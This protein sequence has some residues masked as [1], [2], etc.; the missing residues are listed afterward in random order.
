MT[1][2]LLR[3][4]AVMARAAVCAGLMAL[5]PA[6]QAQD[7][8]VD[9]KAAD[10]AA[11]ARSSGKALKPALTVT[12]IAPQR[13]DIAV[14]VQ[15]TGS[16]AAWQEAIVGAES[17]GLRLAEVRVNVGDAVQRGQVLA[18]FVAES[19]EADLAQ[20]R[21]ALAEAEATFSDARA[22]AVRAREVEGSGA[23]SQQ[24]VAQLLTAEKTAEARLMAQRA[25]VAA[26]ELRLKHATVLAPDEGSISARN[27]TVGAVVP[28]GQELF[29]LIRGDRLE[30]R[31]EVT[32]AEIARI[33]PGQAVSVTAASGAVMS[34]RVRVI[35]PTVDAQTRNALV[36]VDLPANAYRSG[37]FKAGMFARGEFVT[38]SGAALTLPLQALSL[39][40]GFSYVFTVGADN[41]VTQV[42]VQVGRRAGERVEVIG[43]LKGDE[44]VVAAGAAF[45]GDGDLVRVIAK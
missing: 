27:A 44:R 19:V 41:R 10:K 5:L 16:I 30:W 36:Y 6:G 15:A 40:D 2:T 8:P 34:G 29:R 4:R 20:A 24:Q 11:A 37:A 38:G 35:A 12:T 42:K 23:L 17:G 33:R 18:T 25:Q 45:L 21:A 22:N 7:K 28:Q 43:T 3:G 32:S 31:A 39:R 9:A 13:A 26:Q 1:Q 14:T